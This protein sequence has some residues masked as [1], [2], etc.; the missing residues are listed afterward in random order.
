[1]TRA[2]RDGHTETWYA[3]DAVLGWGPDG[4]RRLVATADPGT[5]PE[6]ATRYLVTNLPRPSSPREAA[7][8]HPAADLGEIVRIYGTRH[9]TGQSYE[10]VKDPLGPSAT[11]DRAR[12]R[13][14]GGHPPPRRDHQ[15]PPG[16]RHYARYAPGS[17]LRSRCSAGGR[18][19]RTGPRRH[20]Y[21]P[22]LTRSHQAT[23]CTSTARTN[24]LPLTILNRRG[25]RRV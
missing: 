6:K 23:A 9:W 24:K 4:A 1:V 20:S 15:R 10:Q 25:Y 13:R 14:E 7:S 19:S 16:R 2:F 17:T 5:L 18:H 11:A 3:A 8:P 21:K 22:S 12:P